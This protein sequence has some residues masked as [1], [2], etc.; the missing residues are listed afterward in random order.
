[1]DIDKVRKNKLYEYEKYSYIRHF[2]KRDIF[3]HVTFDNYEEFILEC[4]KFIGQRTQDIELQHE[5]CVNGRIFRING[6]LPSTTILQLNV[7]SNIFESNFK[8]DSYLDEKGLS[9]NKYITK[10]LLSEF[11]EE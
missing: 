9:V 6:K 1:M 2:K 11:L 5:L 3:R 7:N 4:K 8:T 10:M